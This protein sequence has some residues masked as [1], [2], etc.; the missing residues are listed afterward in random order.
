MIALK[1]CELATLDDAKACVSL[2]A[3]ALG[4]RLGRPAAADPALSLA[5]AIAEALGDRA[6]V[7]GVVG[8][9]VAD[10]ELELLK[11]ETGVACLQFEGPR[12]RERAE[13]HLPHAYPSL[14]PDALA[15]AAPGFAGG[16]VMARLEAPPGDADARA[17][18]ALG[19]LAR[20]KRL[21]LSA[22]FTPDAARAAL[23][24]LRP[25]CLDLRPLPSEKGQLDPRRVGALLEV[26]REP[27]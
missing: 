22:P 7:V 12:A 3:H 6:L 9:E 23:A 2:G 24:R 11:R 10:D 14:P 17:W 27:A 15:R 13:R 16:Y 25:Y 21:A 1:V 18:A 5:A 26:L 8:P 19:A 4:V 20:A